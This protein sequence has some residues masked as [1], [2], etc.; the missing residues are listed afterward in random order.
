M[1]TP[2]YARL[3]SITIFYNGLHG[4]LKAN[5]DGVS[6]GAFMNN[7]YKQACQLIED[8]AMNSYM[9]P[10]ECSSYSQMSSMTKV[11]K[12]DDKYKQILEKLHHLESIVKPSMS[13]KRF[14]S[15]HNC[16]KKP[17]KLK[18]PESFAIPVE[19]RKKHFSKAHCVIG[20]RINLIPLS[21]YL[22]LRLGELK[23]S[24]II[25][26]LADRSLT[27]PEGVLEGLL[28]KVRGFIIPFDFTLLDF[29]EDQD[30][31]IPLG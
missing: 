16:P 6:V 26:Q 19:I 4:S 2:C 27:H 29:K 8:M 9:W 14:L 1:P 3:A 25:L 5:L 10:N 31:P 13:G 21:T 15:C 23:N 17:L 30:I 28:I 7:T 22:K 18:Y 12:E 20:A 11:V 24:A